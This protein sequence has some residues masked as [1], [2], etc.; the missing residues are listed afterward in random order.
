MGGFCGHLDCGDGTDP[1]FLKNP[2]EKEFPPRK[3]HSRE[4]STATSS[5]APQRKFQEI[6]WDEGHIDGRADFPVGE[7]DLE[8]DVFEENGKGNISVE[9]DAEIEHESDFMRDSEDD[10]WNEW[11]LQ[12][13]E[14]VWNLNDNLEK[15]DSRFE[16][17]IKSFEKRNFGFEEF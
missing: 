2:L 12:V 13:D 8:R 14:K 4:T 11:A 5:N 15:K 17:R 3:K 16:W 6:E 10:E 1:K 9:K 7:M